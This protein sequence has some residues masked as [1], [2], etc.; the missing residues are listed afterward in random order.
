MNIARV[1]SRVADGGHD[2]PVDKIRSR[3]ARAFSL[4]PAVIDVSD[5]MHIYDNTKSLERIFKKRKDQYFYW[6][7]FF[8]NK[9]RIESLTGLNFD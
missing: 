5:I 3:Y 9:T 8:W 2:V 4:I 7:N 1:K 6:E